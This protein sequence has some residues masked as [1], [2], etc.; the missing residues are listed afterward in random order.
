[1]AI[2]R[3]TE[4]GHHIDDP[5]EPETCSYGVIPECEDPTAGF[6]QIRTNV[7][8]CKSCDWLVVADNAPTS[9]PS[10]NAI[11]CPNVTG[12]SFDKVCD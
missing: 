2:W 10:V 1:M 9:C 8:K 4:C 12:G 7:W 6:D 3:H 5:G 11:P